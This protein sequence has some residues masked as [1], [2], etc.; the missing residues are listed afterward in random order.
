M[1]RFEKGLFEHGKCPKGRRCNYLHVFRNPS[2]KSN[3]KHK[4]SKTRDDSN[5]KKKSSRH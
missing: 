1:I 2:L 5:K 3:K 4:H